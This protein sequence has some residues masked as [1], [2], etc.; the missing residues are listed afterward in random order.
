MFV[1]GEQAPLVLLLFFVGCAIAVDAGFKVGFPAGFNGGSDID[2]VPP[3]DR[4]GVA[5]ARN[6]FLPANVL[7]GFEVPLGGRG[8]VGETGGILAA[9]L[10]PVGGRGEGGKTDKGQKGQKGPKGRKGHKLK[11]SVDCA[12]VCRVLPDERV[13]CA[14]GGRPLKGKPSRV[15]RFVYRGERK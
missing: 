1:E 8:L 6:G 5:Q 4:A 10:G 3:D 2:A 15:W 11:E 12:V 9:K 14:L 13:S 7:A